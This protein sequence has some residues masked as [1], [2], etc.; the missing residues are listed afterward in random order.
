MKIEYKGK[1]SVERKAAT[2]T[3]S[4]D[5]TRKTTHVMTRPKTDLAAVKMLVLGVCSGSLSLF[6][7]GL[8]RGENTSSPSKSEESKFLSM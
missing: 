3:I 7:F 6:L 4:R 5:K 8:E 1:E 2:R